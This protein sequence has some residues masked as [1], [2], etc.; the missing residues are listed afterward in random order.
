MSKIIAVAAVVL[1]LIAVPAYGATA[2]TS[3]DPIITAP[4]AS[5]SVKSGW[6]GP[7]TIDFTNAPSGAF[8]ATLSC[9]DY[10]VL[11]DHTFHNQSGTS[12]DVQNWQLGA[13]ITGP[14]SCKISV[15]NYAGSRATNPFTVDPPPLKLSNVR[16]T[17]AGFYPLVRDGYKD[18][19]EVDWTINREA[20]VNVYVRHAGRVVR[21]SGG[22]DDEKAGRWYWPWNG[23]KDNGTIAK[24]GRYS[25]LVIAR[26][27]GVVRRETREVI[28]ATGYR[29]VKTTLSK[30]GYG[31][32]STR[33][34]R[35]CGV[36]FDSYY[37]TVQLTCFDGGSAKA[38]YRFRLRSGA[39]GIHWTV[40]GDVVSGNKTNLRLP[41]K[42]I[43]SRHYVATVKVVQDLSYV[44]DEVD[45]TYWRKV[46]I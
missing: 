19:T 36:D 26:A 30:S 1:S 6:I 8:D 13:P 33:H 21:H 25:I 11:R 5:G 46:K 24:P 43:D 28:V 9:N 4:V 27:N 35:Y 7:V 15:T 31:T 39:Y 44:V 2:S 23:R 20:A 17:R 42:R 32:S 29:R 40:Y 3:D 22:W 14:K 18:S 10:A 34:D 45:L 37:S 12:D 41:G 38:N 16:L